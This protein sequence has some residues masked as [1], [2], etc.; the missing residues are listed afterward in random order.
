L[1][2]RSASSQQGAGSAHFLRGLAFHNVAVAQVGPGHGN[3]PTG[4]DDFGRMNVSGNEEDRYRFRTTPLRN[5][6][7]TAPYGHDGAIIDLRAFIE[8]YSES[9]KKL[10]AFDVGQLEPAVRGTLVPNASA[11]LAQRDT[12]LNGVVLPDDIV[13]KLMDYM[14][15]L[16]DDAARNLKHVTPHR[17]PSGLSVDRP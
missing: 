8:H 15:A 14:R 5:V 10:L 7:L 11:I 9:D 13:D 2:T 16:T 12:I 6:E 1:P 4:L 17:V 3:G